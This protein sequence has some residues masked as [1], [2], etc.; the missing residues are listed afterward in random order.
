LVILGT[1]SLHAQSPNLGLAKQ[2]QE[3]VNRGEYDQLVELVDSRD[4]LWQKSPSMAYFGDMFSLGE[5]LMGRTTDRIYWLGR[6]VIWKMLFKPIPNEYLAPRKF[7]LSRYQMF[8][9]GVEDISAYVDNLSPG[10]FAAV[11]HDTFLML[12]EYAKQ[13]HQVY[14]PNYR[15]K[16]PGA[17]NDAAERKKLIQNEIDNEIQYE[18]RSALSSLATD[19]VDYLIEAYSHDPRDDEELKMLLDILNVQG[20]YRA[21]VVR[22]T[23]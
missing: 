18:T 22:G 7:Y 2:A 21:K 17:M 13:L 12:W 1:V 14:D 3:L 20:A 4:A 16:W 19:H 9:E 8:S 11:R 23:P 6:K 5:V 10:K 15:Q